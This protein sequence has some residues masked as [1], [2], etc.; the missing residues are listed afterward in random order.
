MYRRPPRSTRTD[1]LFPYSTLFRSEA[2]DEVAAA[3]TRKGMPFA[4][5]TGYGREALPEA[6]RHAPLLNK[7]LLPKSAFDMLE[8]L[9]SR[10]TPHIGPTAAQDEN[11]TAKLRQSRRTE[12]SRVGKEGVRTCST[13]GAQEEKKKQKK[14]NE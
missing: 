13:R 10:E 9:L 14:I 3:L 12:E 2:V 4:F 11:L 6:F 8:K 7:P 1:T 5:V